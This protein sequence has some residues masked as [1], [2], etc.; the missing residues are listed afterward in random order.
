M[1][2]LHGPHR[3]RW[4]KP[5][6]IGWALTGLPAI[7]LGMMYAGSLNPLPI[8]DEFE[9]FADAATWSLVVAWLYVTPVV[10]IVV[11]R[12]YRRATKASDQ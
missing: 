5:V 8:P 3:P 6:L 4:F 12:R 2:Y 9:S 1:S 7:P 10:L 11:E